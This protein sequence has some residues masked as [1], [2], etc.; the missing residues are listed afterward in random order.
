[1]CFLQFFKNTF[2][3]QYLPINI[4]SYL[5]RIILSFSS[6]IY[7]TCI[8]PIYI[9]F[10][11]FSAGTLCLISLLSYAITHL[12][13]ESLPF[14]ITKKRNVKFFRNDYVQRSTASWFL[15]FNI[16]F[17]LLFAHVIFF[18]V[19]LQFVLYNHVNI[20]AKHVL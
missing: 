5:S 12:L 2:Y 6:Y 1:M 3:R 13:S 20:F 10:Y 17:V 18:S 4:Y 8:L 11:Y 16:K 14:K 9:Y 15:I 19:H 7:Y